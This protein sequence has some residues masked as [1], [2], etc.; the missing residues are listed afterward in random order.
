MPFYRLKTGIVHMRGTKMPA[1]CAARIQLDGQEQPCLAPSGFLCDG[2][3]EQRKTCDRPLCDA[4]ALQIA[5]NKHL[6][7]PCHL[8]H[9]DAAAQRGLFTSLV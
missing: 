3:S 8:N 6:C 7:P 2:P 5:A 4:H 1:P 9:R